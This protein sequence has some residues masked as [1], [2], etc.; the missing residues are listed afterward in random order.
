MATTQDW[1]AGARPRTLPMAVAPVVIG[2]AAAAGLGSFDLLIGALAMIVALALQV[3][4]N[5]A[6][7]Y[8]DGVRG[9]DDARVG[10]MRLTA[11]G[12]A[13]PAAVKA[14]AFMSFGVAGVAGLVIVALS[15]MWWMVAVGALCVLAAW[16][17]TGGSR[18][19]GY[20]GLGEVM[21]F[22]FFGLVA[23]LGTTWVM[24]AQLSAAAV[25]G[26]VGAGLIAS[27]LLMANNVRDIPTDTESGKLT[28]AVR[29]G[30]RK[31]RTSYV[32][33]IGVA[34]LLPLSLAT[35]NPWF[36]L[37]VLVWPLCAGPVR[38]MLSSRHTGSA[39][40]TVLQLTGQVSLA[41]AATMTAAI[42]LG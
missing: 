25:V 20:L 28:L 42:L 8:S 10:P 5:Y 2:A 15:G 29:L 3:G 35:T 22:V 1:I 36:L 19:Y 21:V 26:A 23:T 27:A 33:M 39:L 6:N 18:P 14:A 32:A 9:T 37:V 34:V 40:I 16:W 11:S 30:E 12:T 13:S 41:F 4:V 31:A 7:D 38:I 17:Y 24:A